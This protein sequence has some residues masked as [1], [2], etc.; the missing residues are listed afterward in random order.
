MDS[1][2]DLT[3][4]ANKVRSR[5]A[6]LA[7][8]LGG[9]GVWVARAFGDRVDP[10]QAAA[11]DPIRMGQVNLASGTNTVLQTISSGTAY[12]VRQN[13]SGTA[14]RA[15]SPHGHAGVFE[16]NAELALAH[17][18]LARHKGGLNTPSDFAA[19]RAESKYTT[20]ISAFSSISTAITARSGQQVGVFGSSR[21]R[22]GVLG[23]SERRN[24]VE[25]ASLD[26]AGIYGHS[27]NGDG[28]V[29]RGGRWAA[30]FEGSVLMDGNINFRER[31]TPPVP[32]ADHAQLF[33]RDNGAGKSQLVV[34]F[35]SGA[36]HVV[37]TEP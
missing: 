35:P 4:A 9:V 22:E 16:T 36:I 11:G 5:R 15:E 27:R 6:V 28:I 2:T 33:L 21:H 8:V 32:T 20:A 12:L 34:Q 30:R 37:V 17:A 7:G 1:T 31:V 19:I 29:G 14:I 25:G 24:G 18:I 26:G 3:G 10:A 13:G 23:S